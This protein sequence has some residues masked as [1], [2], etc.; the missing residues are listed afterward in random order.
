M[1]TAA[2]ALLLGTFPEKL[3]EIKHRVTLISWRTK[4]VFRFGF[5]TFNAF[6]QKPLL[7][8]CMKLV[9]LQLTVYMV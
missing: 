1:D 6:F 2:V 9:N 5:A 3:L 4:V 7:K 8:R